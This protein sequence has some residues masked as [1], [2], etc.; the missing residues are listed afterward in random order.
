MKDYL[1]EKLS[2]EEDNEIRGIICKTAQKHK[3]KVYEERQR[4]IENIENHDSA[5]NDTY[6]VEEQLL[7]DR[8]IL[9]PFL[10]QE[11]LILVNKLDN[12]LEGLELSEIKRTL[13][14]NEK[15]VFVLVYMHELSQSLVA[16]LLGVQRKTIYNRCKSIDK[17]IQ[18]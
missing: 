1:K 2:E 4:G 9:H 15:L 14:F 8:D 12:L 13:T 5:I 3:L 16:K 10:K 17:K 7:K 18:R 11:K 6:K